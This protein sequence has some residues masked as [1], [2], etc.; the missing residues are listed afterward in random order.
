MATGEHAIKGKL[1]EAYPSL[2]FFK[3]FIARRLLQ[4]GRTEPL[5]CARHT[6][7]HRVC[8]IAKRLGLDVLSDIVFWHSLVCFEIIYT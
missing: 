5:V 2:I 4:P 8:V 6:F 7:I 3:G 1:G